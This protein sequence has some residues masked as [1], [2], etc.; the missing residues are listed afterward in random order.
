MRRFI[1]LPI[2]SG[3]LASCD[4]GSGRIDGPYLLDMVDIPEDG[5]VCYEL[6]DGDCV[7]RIPQT[8]FAVGYN[9]DF[10]VAARHPHR[11]GD[12]TLD[13]SRAEYFYIV[14]SLDGPLVT[15]ADSVRGPFDLATFE[16]Y[17]R[18]L[19]LPVFTREISSLK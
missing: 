3:L 8:V 15:P 14:R 13:R 6:E 1:F 2:L 18:S 7:E 5:N 19:G 12:R 11:F 10:I 4:G 16:R 17:R 9:S